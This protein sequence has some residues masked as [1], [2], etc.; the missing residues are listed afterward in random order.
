MV[1]EALNLAW[2]GARAEKPD[3][4]VTIDKSLD[5]DAGFADLYPQEMTRVL[6]NLISNGFYATAKRG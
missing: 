2:H 5:P 1:E 6:L 4:K 3:L